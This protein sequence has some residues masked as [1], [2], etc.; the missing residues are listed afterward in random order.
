MSTKGWIIS[1]ICSP[2]LMIMKRF[3]LI[4]L[5]IAASVTA[6]KAQYA[7]SLDISS[8]GSS[9]Y[10]SG[11]KLTAQ[12]AADLFSDFGGA[13]MGEDYLSNRR[14]FRTGLGLTIAGPPAF[15]LGSTAYVVGALMTLDSTLSPMSYIVCYTGATM[16]VSG[17]LMTVA[18]IPTLCIYRN[19]IKNS[20]AEYNTKKSQP[21]LTFSPASSGIGVAMTF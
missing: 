2:T 21:V 15:V 20:V 11:E 19:R 9:I 7:R 4:L 1:Y 3:I 10:V 12:Q 18:G 8:R 16:A 13:Q 5:L 6:A 14:G 17:A